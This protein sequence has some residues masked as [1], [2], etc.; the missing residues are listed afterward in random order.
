[1]SAL[2]LTKLPDEVCR[3]AI[4]QPTARIEENHEQQD[5][6]PYELAVSL[7]ISP[8]VGFG[9]ILTL[10]VPRRAHRFFPRFAFVARFRSV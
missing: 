1:M 8:V 5:Q 9:E 2:K 6:C 7:G 3:I 4:H 10:S